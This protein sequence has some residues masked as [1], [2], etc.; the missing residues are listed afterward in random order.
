MFL[1]INNQRYSC[2]RRIV[3][4]QSVTYIGVEPEPAEVSGIIAMYRD[5]G[6]LMSEDDTAG[7]ERKEYGGTVLKLSNEPIVPPSPYEPTADD[8]LNQI[9]GVD[10]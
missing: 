3:K 7:Y 2:T 6:F 4:P 10:E 5:D 8:V 1:N 9:L